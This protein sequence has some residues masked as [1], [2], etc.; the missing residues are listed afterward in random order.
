M[1]NFEYVS[2]K[3]AATAKNE[4]IEII[5]GVQKILRNKDISFQFQFIGSSSRNMI[6]CDRKSNIGY[7][8][9]V[10]LEVFYDDDRYDP[11]EIKHIM[12][13]AFNLVVRR[14]GYGYCEDSTR[15]FS[16]KKIDHWRSRIIQ[17]RD[18]AIVNN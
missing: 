12:M 1:Y 7:D 15:V 14:Y 8:F 16:I 13:D 11:R 4:L 3:E 6:T 5:N 10:D 9:D 17:G 18:F 2:K